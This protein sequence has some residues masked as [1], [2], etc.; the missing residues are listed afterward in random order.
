MYK[1]CL[2]NTILYINPN[3]ITTGKYIYLIFLI[4][5]QHIVRNSIKTKAYKT[6]QIINII[7]YLIVIYK[8]WNY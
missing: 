8:I 1:I 7:L 6:P 3:T 2:S 4:M 5:I